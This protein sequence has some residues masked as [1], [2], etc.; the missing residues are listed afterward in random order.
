M[1]PGV[2]AGGW[3]GDLTYRSAARQRAATPRKDGGP[4]RRSAV[5]AC[6]KAWDLT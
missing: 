5:I 4:K 2:T 6:A 1:G 3:R